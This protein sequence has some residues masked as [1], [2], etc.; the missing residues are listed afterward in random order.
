MA[1][2]TSSETLQKQVESA[3]GAVLTTSTGAVT[4]N[5]VTA[6]PLAATVDVDTQL[7]ALPILEAKAME[8]AT[9]SGSH[10]SRHN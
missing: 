1:L 2:P 4:D 10:S 7:E 8:V 6:T 9:S 3:G 5:K